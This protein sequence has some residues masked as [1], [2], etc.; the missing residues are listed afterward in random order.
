MS[1]IAL[2]F[3]SL[4]FFGVVGAITHGAAVGFYIYEINYFLNPNSR[5]WFSALPSLK[6]SFLIS[7]TTVIAFLLQRKRYQGNTFKSFP[8]AIWFFLLFVSFL[9]STFWAVAPEWH[10]RFI[11]DTIKLYV[12]IYVAYRIIDTDKKL[13]IALICY[14]LGSAYIG[15]EAMRVGRDE[16]GRVEGIGMIDSPDANTVAAALVPTIPFIIYYVWHLPVKYKI[17]VGFLGLIIANGLVLINSRGAFL[18]AAAATAY[19]VMYMAFSKYKMPKQRLMLVVLLISISGATIRLTD[20]TFWQRM[21]TLEEQTSK[22]SEGSG[23]RR[24]N[25][26]IATFDMMED[27]PLGAGIY[28]YQYLSTFY[29]KDESWLSVTDG[30]RARAVHS[31]WFEGLSTVGWHGMFAF[32]MLLFALKRGLSEVKKIALSNY[33]HQ[34]YYF[35]IS[36]EAAFIGFCISAS[37]IDVFRVQILYWLILYCAC[38]ISIVKTKASTQKGETAENKERVI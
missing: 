6:Y 34:Q 1:K 25:F 16:F 31:M 24:I 37:F 36:I 18:G 26:W 3:I 29:L 4:I 21:G 17:F 33:D 35:A 7:G 22:D 9:L 13:N 38:F 2:A 27:Y 23:G 12:I 19:F 10:N 11:I 15:Y 28:G 14:L 30:R 8:G 20:D 32:L 5:W